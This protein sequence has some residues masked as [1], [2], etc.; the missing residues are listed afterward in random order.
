M[1][2]E[3]QS[4]VSIELEGLKA[5][6]VLTVRLGY[7]D[8]LKT[9]DRH[10]AVSLSCDCGKRSSRRCGRG[11]PVMW[12]CPPH[13]DRVSYLP[14]LQ[15]VTWLLLLLLLCTRQ[16]AFSTNSLVNSFGF[17]VQ[18]VEKTSIDFL[19]VYNNSADFQKLLKK[20]VVLAEA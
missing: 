6:R 19:V 4:S 18:Q 7:F 20:C 11:S 16:T 14:P 1:V 8:G 3:S 12:G 17:D 15:A 2:D 5:K 9:A 10:A 13:A